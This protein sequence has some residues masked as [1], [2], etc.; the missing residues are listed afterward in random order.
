[1]ASAQIGNVMGVPALNTNDSFICDIIAD[2]ANT[3]TVAAT[4]SG[5]FYVGQVII[6]RV[7]ATGAV[8]GAT[9]RTITALGISGFDTL[10]TYSG[11]DIA[12]V[13]GT[14]AIHNGNVPAAS[15]A[16]E[17]TNLN[18][19]SDEAAGFNDNNLLTIES[20]KKA[21]ALVIPPAIVEVMT[22]NDLVYACRVTFSPT[23]IK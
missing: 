8:F 20:M 6:F 12:V 11:A 22:Y 15:I 3:V 21:L 17:H 19:G 4:K 10:I 1:M 5:F 9:S 16:Q 18:G 23:T 14:H 13:P 7:K 2:G